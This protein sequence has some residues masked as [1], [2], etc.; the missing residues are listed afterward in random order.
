MALHADA[1]R[2]QLA[3]VDG[4]AV[5]WKAAEDRLR[6]EDVRDPGALLRTLLPRP[7]RLPQG[8][9]GRGRELA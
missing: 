4:N 6:A 5:S 2:L 9:E 1:V 7:E 8:A 3:A